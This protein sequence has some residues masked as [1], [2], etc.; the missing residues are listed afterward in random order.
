MEE[1]I[2]SFTW[3]CIRTE[4]LSETFGEGFYYMETW[5]EQFEATRLR[6]NINSTVLKQNFFFC[7]LGKFSTQKYEQI[8]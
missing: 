2:F 3:T 6:G 1:D 7:F 8:G 4:Q 5:M